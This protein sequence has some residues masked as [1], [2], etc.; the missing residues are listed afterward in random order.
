MKKFRLLLLD[1]NVVIELF[2]HSIWDKLIDACDIHL[3]RT[4]AQNEAQFYID[5]HGSKQYFNL[6]QDINEGNITVFDIIP[7]ELIEFRSQFDSTYF[8]RLDLGEAESLAYLIN[9]TKNC[10]ICSA[11]SIVYKVLGNLNKTE[12]GISLEEILQ[13]VGLTQPLSWQFTRK[14]REHWTQKGFM[15]QLGGIGRK[16]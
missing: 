6:E 1:A 11:D 9:S 2:R 8:E 3:S 4:V 12:Q 15:E 16:E 5:E 7:S 13:K 14:F 10:N